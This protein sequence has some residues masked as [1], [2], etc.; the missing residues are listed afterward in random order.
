MSS[1]AEN[2]RAMVKGVQRE[3]SRLANMR[4][5][6]G[7]VEYRRARRAYE[8][9]F[10][11]ELE[12]TGRWEALPQELFRSMLSIAVGLWQLESDLQGRHGECFSV[13]GPRHEVTP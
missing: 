9:H 12:Y 2:E 7:T 3:I 8:R 1:A 10:R 5:A 6:I 4:F 13:S 11:A